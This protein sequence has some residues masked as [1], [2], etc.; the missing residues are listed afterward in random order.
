MLVAG[1]DGPRRSAS[2]SSRSS[3]MSTKPH[4]QL[5]SITIRQVNREVRMIRTCMERMR[6]LATCLN[7][8]PCQISSSQTLQDDTASP[9]VKSFALMM[10][11]CARGGQRTAGPCAHAPGAGCHASHKRCCSCVACHGPWAGGA[12]DRACMHGVWCGREACGTWA[13]KDACAHRQRC[14]ADSVVLP[15]A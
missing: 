2:K 6:T 14:N 10:S 15:W 1:G 8:L 11:M 3:A 7:Y 12:E 13:G 5:S 4:G 9:G